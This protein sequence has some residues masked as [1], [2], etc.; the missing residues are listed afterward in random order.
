MLTKRQ[1]VAAWIKTDAQRERE[2]AVLAQVT[3][4]LTQSAR[5]KAS[6][7]YTIGAEMAAIWRRNLARPPSAF[8]RHFAKP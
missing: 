4:R 3:E 8:A 6:V 2:A 7:D 5:P 1:R